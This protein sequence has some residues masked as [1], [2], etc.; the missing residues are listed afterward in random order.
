MSP[1]NLRFHRYS[2]SDREYFPLLQTFSTSWISTS[3]VDVLIGHPLMCSFTAVFFEQCSLKRCWIHLHVMRWIPESLQVVRS[4]MLYCSLFFEHLTFF[5]S[6]RASF[7]QMWQLD[8]QLFLLSSVLLLLLKTIFT[9]VG[10]VVL[11]SSKQT[12]WLFNDVLVS[13]T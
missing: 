5:S 2:L 4:S 1:F 12:F 11:I 7:E 8:L 3:F 10:A 13:L 9:R 6:P